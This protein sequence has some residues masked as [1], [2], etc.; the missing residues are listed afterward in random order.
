MAAVNPFVVVLRLSGLDGYGVTEK[1]MREYYVLGARAM[2]RYAR[3]RA[4]VPHSEAAVDAGAA[5]W[6]N[7]AELTRNIE[8]TWVTN[9]EDFTIAVLEAVDSV[10]AGDMT[11]AAEISGE[12]VV[13]YSDYT[14]AE[15]ADVSALAPPGSP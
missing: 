10:R 14:Y 4:S 12:L 5:I 13:M 9:P 1:D 8:N 7:A 6:Q 11:R 3:Q 15:A 2:N